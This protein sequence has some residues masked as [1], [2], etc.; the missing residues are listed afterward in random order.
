MNSSVTKFDYQMKGE[1]EKNTQ[2]KYGI[3]LF[4]SPKLVNRMNEFVVPTP[5]LLFILFKRSNLIRILP[6]KLVK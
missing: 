4:F 1:D 3:K 6:S 2:D 5:L